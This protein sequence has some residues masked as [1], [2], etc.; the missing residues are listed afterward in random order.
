MSRRR[1]RE[2]VRRL[3]QVKK[4]FMIPTV[5]NDLKFFWLHVILGQIPPWSRY[6]SNSWVSKTLAKWKHT[7]YVFKKSIVL[8]ICTLLFQIINLLADFGG[9]IGL[10]IGFSVITFVEFLELAVELLTLCYRGTRARARA[11]GNKRRPRYARPVAFQYVNRVA[12]ESFQDRTPSVEDSERSSIA[13]HAS[14][15]WMYHF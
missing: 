9:N 10:W 5:R 15:T 7:E 1:W 13:A 11:R 3:C 12:E 4:Y 14:K 6:S 8:S 2:G